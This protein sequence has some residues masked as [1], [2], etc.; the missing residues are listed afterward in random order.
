MAM[1]ATIALSKSTASV[2]MPVNAAVT[3]SNSGGAAVTVTSMQPSMITTGFA[4]DGL[5]AALGV[6]ALGPGINLVVPAGGSLILGYTVVAFAV[7]SQS[8]TYS[9]GAAISTSDGSNFSPTPATL[10]VI[11]INEPDST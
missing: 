6:T 10:T 8:G 4:N 2:N 9:L 3:I 11:A 1:S 5:P 7:P